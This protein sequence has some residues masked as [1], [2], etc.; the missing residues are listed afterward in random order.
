M[1]IVGRCRLWGDA[2]SAEMVDPRGDAR[3]SEMV[4][5]RGDARSAE[6]GDG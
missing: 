3:R 5:P 2:R 6:L 1:T 4:D